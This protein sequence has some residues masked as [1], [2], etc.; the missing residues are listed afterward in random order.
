MCA[1]IKD[2]DYRVPVEDNGIGFDTPYLDR[3][4]KPFPCLHRREEL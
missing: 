4:S 2:E 3:I 1:Q